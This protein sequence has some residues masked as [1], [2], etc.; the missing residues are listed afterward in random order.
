[1]LAYSA[2]FAAAAAAGGGGG[3]GTATHTE[4]ERERL[5]AS[6]VGNDKARQYSAVQYR[7]V[8]REYGVGV[9]CDAV[10]MLM[11]DES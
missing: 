9:D 4:R 5:I 10:L 1:M 7:V 3:G 8:Y 2:G 11:V 6:F